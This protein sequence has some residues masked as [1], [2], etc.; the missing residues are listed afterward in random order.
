[1]HGTAITS[2]YLAWWQSVKECYQH[3]NLRQIDNVASRCPSLPVKYKL[4]YK[5][6]GFQ[7]LLVVCSVK[8]LQLITTLSLSY[9][10]PVCSCSHVC[11]RWILWWPYTR[12]TE[13]Q[14]QKI[15]KTEWKHASVH[16]QKSISSKLAFQVNERCKISVYHCICN[17][18]ILVHKD[19]TFLLLYTSV[20]RCSWFYTY[21]VK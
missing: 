20:N 4:L 13:G 14:S 9:P 5:H 3:A 15:K 19:V 8:L 21:A 16:L 1:M 12:G 18:N 10:L 17:K 2:L 6:Y 7:L 11:Y